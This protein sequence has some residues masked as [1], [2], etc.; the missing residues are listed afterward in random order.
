MLPSDSS[1]Q[2]GD[3]KKGID[4]F[5]KGKEQGTSKP[6]KR[7][8]GGG[9][10]TAP[11][12]YKNSARNFSYTIPA[13][14]EKIEGEPNSESVGFKKAGTSWG[15]SIS[16]NQ[17][18]PSFPRKA[19]VETS[20]KQ[21]KERVTIKQLLEAKRRDDGDPKKKCGVIG[22]EIVEAPQKAGIQRIIRQCYDSE[23]YYMNLMAYSSTEDFA[24][25]RATLRE[26]MDSIKF[27]R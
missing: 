21:E 5:Q 10:S 11:V 16:M 14:W 4:T 23:N 13:G 17:M 25:A 19:S 20:L 8:I 6:D 22:W 27:C 26:I 7:A 12:T 2:W 1:A 3:I 18:V 9:G 15:F 24:A